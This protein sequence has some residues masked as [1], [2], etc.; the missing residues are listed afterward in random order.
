MGFSSL[1]AREVMLVDSQWNCP[2]K[3]GLTVLRAHLLSV[4]PDKLPIDLYI[5]GSS[6]CDIWRYRVRIV[7]LRI[8]FPIVFLHEFFSKVLVITFRKHP[9]ESHGIEVTASFDRFLRGAAA[10][11]RQR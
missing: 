7:E 8:P 11:Q 1:I 10:I 9:A 6:F 3:H 2:K 5:R 4:V